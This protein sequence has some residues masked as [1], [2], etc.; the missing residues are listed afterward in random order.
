MLALVHDA[1]SDHDAHDTHDDT[2]GAEQDGQLMVAPATVLLLCLLLRLAPVHAVTQRAGIASRHLGLQAVT[3][4]N[5]HHTLHASQGF[6]VAGVE[7][8]SGTST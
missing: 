5:A 8:P 2:K 7:N 4:W 6:C 1:G 3:P